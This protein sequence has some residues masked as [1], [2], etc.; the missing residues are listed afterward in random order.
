MKRISSLGIAVGVTALLGG[1]AVAQSD[2]YGDDPYEADMQDEGDVDVDVDVNVEPA[3]YD[4]TQPPAQQPQAQQPQPTHTTERETT[5][6]V[7]QPQPAPEPV[8][9]EYAIRSAIGV[10]V[11]IGGGLTHFIKDQTTGFTDLGGAWEARIAVGTRYPFSVEAAYLGGVQ[12]M[13]ALG[14]DADAMLLANGAELGA[15]FNVLSGVTPV[16]PFVTAGAAW[17]RYDITNSDFNTS[18][19]NNEENVLEIPL[20][21]GI[22]FN[23]GPLLLDLRGTYRPA[24]FDDM[25]RTGE[26]EFGEDS[27]TDLDNWRASLNAGF[28][29]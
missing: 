20:G 5:T 27:A 11:T 16:Q 3:P 29:F 17:K 8:E 24:F 12:D 9:E 2:D 28:A 10:N 22:A 1:T 4:D 14:L 7:V 19:L 13:D 21:A 23:A 25:T 18:N 6:V 15:R 26:D